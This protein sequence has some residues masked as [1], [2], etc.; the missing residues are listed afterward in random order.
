[1]TFGHLTHYINISGKVHLRLL[2]DGVVVADAEYNTDNLDNE[3]IGLWEAS[4]AKR[5]YECAGELCID[6]EWGE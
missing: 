6:F 5:I 3:R 2:R 1:M 4:D